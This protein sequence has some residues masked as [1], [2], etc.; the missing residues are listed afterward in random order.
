[1]NKGQTNHLLGYPQDAR[2]LILNAD[3]FG[4]CHAVNEA[5][6]GVLKAGPIRSTTLMVP[7]PWVPQAIRFLVEHPEIPFGVHL[8]AIS[9]FTD[10]RWN[11]I[12][13]KEKAPSLVDRFGYFHSFD[14]MLARISSIALDELEMEFRAQI[15]VVLAAGLQ[16]THLDWHA[17]RINKRPE[18]PHVLIRLARQ[19]GLALRVRGQEM[20]DTLQAQGFPTNDYDFLDSYLLAPEQK[21][22][23]YIKLLRELPEGLS[24]WAIHP[25]LDYPELLALEPAGRHERQRDYDFWTSQE[26][27][28]IIEQEGIILLDYGPLQE[29]WR[30]HGRK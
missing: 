11:P 1:M 12:L 30:A 19:F 4:V 6:V 27:K 15:E 25:G 13:P 28:E 3:D 24:E 23:Q 9:D 10:Y 22:E 14:E 16:P 17:L 18:V 26:A 8:T 20:I 29:L 7:C 5:I 2:L 21:R